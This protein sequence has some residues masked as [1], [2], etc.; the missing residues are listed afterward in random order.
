MW[1]D[2]VQFTSYADCN[3]YINVEF[4]HLKNEDYPRKICEVWTEN[5]VFPL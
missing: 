5:F 3:E 2:W 1:N 4:N